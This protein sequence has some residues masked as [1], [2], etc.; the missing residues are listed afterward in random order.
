M[1][2]APPTACGTTAE[3]P[4]RQCHVF[5][6]WDNF[7]DLHEMT[8]EGVEYRCR[9]MLGESAEES[10]QIVVDGVRT[11][12]IYPTIKEASPHVAH[13]LRGPDT[14][15]SGVFGQLVATRGMPR[16][17]TRHM[18]SWMSCSYGP[19]VSVRWTK[20]DEVNEA[21]G[22]RETARA[23]TASA[24]RVNDDRPSGC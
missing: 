3:R 2:L 14:G 4:Y 20:V 8:W 19:P 5:G 7:R 1:D 22:K 23:G 15:G 9:V 12:Q 18:M 6:T 10:F 16:S 13:S 11:R 24:E 17:V 21:G